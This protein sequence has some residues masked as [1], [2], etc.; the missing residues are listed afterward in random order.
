MNILRTK[1]IKQSIEETEESDHKL[2]KALGALDL[3]VFGVGIII[4]TGIFVLTGVAAAVYA[5]PAI[6]FSFLVSGF[7]CALAALCYAEFASSV[8]VAGSAYTF[9]YAS[10]GEIIAWIIGWDLILESLVGAS[11]VS[12]SWS[13]YFNT[14]LQYIGLG[15]PDALIGNKPVLFGLPVDLP[16]GFIALALSLVLAVGIQ[17]SSR[18]NLV[19]TSIKLLIVVFFIGFGLFFIKTS[20]WVPFLPPSGPAPHPATSTGGA[21]G[22]LGTPLLQLITGG[23][24]QSFGLAGIISGAAIVF[25]AYLGFD[26]VATTAEETKNPQRDMPIGLLGSLAICTVLYIAVSLVLTG[27]VSYTKLNTAAPMAVAFQS[28]GQGWAAVLVSVG[29]IC[30]LTAVIL[31]S[32]L[33]QSRVIFAM[34]RDSL[35]PPWFGRLH[36]RFQTPYRINIIVG[37]IIALIATFT[38]IADLAELLNIGTLLAFIIVAF[39]VIMLRRTQPDLKRAFRAPFVPWLPIVAILSCFYLMLNLPLITWLR[40]IGWL[41]LGFIIYFAYSLHHSRLAKETGKGEETPPPVVPEKRAS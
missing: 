10:L 1:S 11:A 38:P 21:S 24:Q 18:F 22:A 9:A 4:G 26:T 33:G 32:L 14:I 16:A 8:P 29:A 30:G 40:F 35:L 7:V 2:K 3:T 31:I 41:L 23:V 15:L 28:V 39:A 20:N 13:K 25:F 34:S 17:Q 27:M 5:G 12:V 19:V 6:V 37:I 36:P